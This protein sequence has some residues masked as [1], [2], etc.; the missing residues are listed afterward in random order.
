VYSCASNVYFECISPILNCHHAFVQ[1]A[2]QLDIR[3]RA[4]NICANAGSH[5][6]VTRTM[7]GAGSQPLLYRSAGIHRSSGDVVS[8]R[9]RGKTDLRSAIV[10]R[11]FSTEYPARGCLRNL[12]VLEACRL[13]SRSGR[14]PAFLIGMVR[15]LLDAT[16]GE[17]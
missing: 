10:I 7:V 4:S 1:K 14:V 15:R 3:G 5:Q 9:H 6:A 12:I 17:L 16:L 2:D 11:A 8:C 13:P